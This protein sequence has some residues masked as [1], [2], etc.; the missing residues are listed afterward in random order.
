MKK[1]E[2]K[3]KLTRTQKRILLLGAISVVGATVGKFVHE[4]YVENLDPEAD[5][6]AQ[7]EIFD[8]VGK[9][10]NSYGVNKMGIVA[11]TARKIRRERNRRIKL[12]RKIAELETELKNKTNGNGTK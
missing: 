7:N 5:N 12:E 2:R 1:T 6:L 10:C 8:F 3:S 11:Y 4:H 9:N